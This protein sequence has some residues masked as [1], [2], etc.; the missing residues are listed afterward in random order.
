MARQR[1]RRKISQRIFPMIF[2]EKG[3]QNMEKKQ[4]YE[5]GKCCLENVVL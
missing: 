1:E 4:D 2:E 3:Q 5:E